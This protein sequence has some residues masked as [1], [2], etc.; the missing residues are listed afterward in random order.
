MDVWSWVKVVLLLGVL[1][2]LARLAPRLYA[3]GWPGRQRHLR[4]LDS[5][6]LSSE[7]SVHLI[8]VDDVRLVVGASRGGITL[9][10][11]LPSESQARRDDQE[12]LPFGKV[13]QGANSLQTRVE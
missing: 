11:R 4:L 12:T 2:V 1:L 13:D 8:A 6:Y 7:R 9:L 5:L 10:E 3:R